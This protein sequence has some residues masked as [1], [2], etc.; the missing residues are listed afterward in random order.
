MIHNFVR[1]HNM[2]RITALLV[3]LFLLSS[4]FGAH[5]AEALY[6]QQDMEAFDS[7]VRFLSAFALAEPGRPAATTIKRG[8]FAAIMLQYLGYGSGLTADGAG[9]SDVPDSKS[10]IYAMAQLGLMNGYPDGTFR[11]EEDVLFEQAVTVMVTALGYRVKAESMGGYATG[12][13]ACARQLNLLSGISSQQGGILTYFDFVRMMVN[14]LTIDLMEPNSVGGYSIVTDKTWLNTR[15][16]TEERNGI[17]T[18]FHAVSLDGSGK[19]PKNTIAIDGVVYDIEGDYSHLLGCYTEFYVDSNDTVLYITEKST[20]RVELLPEDLLGYADKAYTAE[21]ESGKSKQYH[22]SQSSYILFNGAAADRLSAEDMCPKYG[23]VT[24]IDNNKDGRYD[25][26]LI[27]SY[28]IYVVQNV[29]REDRR[30][31]VKNANGNVL[32]FGALSDGELTVTN[33]SGKEMDFSQISAD[34]VIRVAKTTDGGKARIIVSAKTVSGTITELTGEGRNTEVFIDDMPYKVTEELDLGGVSVGRTSTFYLDS[35]NLIA[36]ISENNN[37]YSYGYLLG[38]R[39]GT[40]QTVQLHLFDSTG[41]LLTL[42]GA[43]RMDIDGLE[44]QDGRAVYELLKKGNSQVPRQMIRFQCNGKGEIREIDT[45]YN[46]AEDIKAQPQNGESPE[47][48]RLTY[49]GTTKYVRQMHN[50]AGKINVDADTLVFAIIGENANEYRIKRVTDLPNETN[51]KLEAYA[52]DANEFYAK[53][54]FSSDRIIKNGGSDG[55]VL[56]VVSKVGRALDDEGEAVPYI[57]FTTKHFEKKLYLEEELANPFPYNAVQEP[58]YPLE[59]GDVI[60]V[61]QYAGDEASGVSL[62]YQPRQGLFPAGNRYGTLAETRV[63]Y[64]YGSV[65]SLEKG[66][67]NVTQKDIAAEGEPMM[68]EVESLRLADFPKILKVSDTGRGKQVTVVTAEDLIDYKTAGENCSKV[69]VAV[70]WQYPNMIVIYE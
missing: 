43:P 25:I 41:Q 12:Y 64:I 15:L 48:L 13:L 36:Y 32:D 69:F 39:L 65:Y 42:D 19:N 40:F 50:F 30:I 53:L 21:T 54:L 70:E 29:N 49:A 20:E 66:F 44:N 57:I 3:S 67:V 28:A 1:K 14:A 45:P 55:E 22:L 27:D 26:A 37:A 23:R 10:P 59:V 58:Q 52:D 31:Y 18:A 46:S 11:P 5:A 34:T 17:V 51:F 6:T 24:L 47:S 62:M 9:F 2:H 68:H 60:S 8:D 7:Q 35:E 33:A 38:A 16:D 4:C 63:H 61:Q 56:G